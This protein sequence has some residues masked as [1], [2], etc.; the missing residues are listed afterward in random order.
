M[1]PP[2]PPSRTARICCRIGCQTPV[3]KATAKYCSVGCC[4][5]DPLRLSLMR[6]RS[7]MASR[8]VLPMSRQLAIPFGSQDAAEQMLALLCEG[9]EDAPLGMARL[10]V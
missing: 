3:K 5:T 1:T 8:Q 9:R 2:T 6:E 7:R 4:S 10:V